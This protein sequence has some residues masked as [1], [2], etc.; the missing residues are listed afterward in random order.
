MLIQASMVSQHYKQRV[1]L[2]KS[3]HPSHGLPRAPPRPLR[4]PRSGRVGRPG[5]PLDPAWPAATDP[6]AINLLATLGAQTALLS[7][8]HQVHYGSVPAWHSRC[9]VCRLGR[10]NGV[11]EALLHLS[12]TLNQQSGP[13]L[14]LRPRAPNVLPGCSAWLPTGSLEPAAPDLGPFSGLDLRNNPH[15]GFRG[16][17]QPSLLNFSFLSARLPHGKAKLQ[18]EM[19]TSPPHSPKKS[20]TRFVT[21][22]AFENPSWYLYTACP[23]LR[24]RFATGTASACCGPTWLASASR[25]GAALVAITRPK[26]SVAALVAGATPCAG[27][28][29]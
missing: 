24:A 18:C 29:L 5:P 6:S 21:L 20:A 25:P 4:K 28:I 8:P 19:S 16:I 9:D 13:P 14:A 10:P 3:C 12:L 27:L 26:K 23:T 7:N 22:T 17:G 1:K 15:P 2:T 11:R